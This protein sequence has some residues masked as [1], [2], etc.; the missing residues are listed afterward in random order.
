[1]KHEDVLSLKMESYALPLDKGGYAA[2]TAIPIKLQQP[3]GPVTPVHTP[4]NSHSSTPFRSPFQ[5]L[6]L[7]EYRKQQKS[8]SSP[9]S[10]VS[11]GRRIKRKAAASRLNEL[12][13]VPSS[14]LAQGLSFSSLTAPDNQQHDARPSLSFA[15]DLSS[16]FDGYTVATRSSISLASD[17]PPYSVSS[18]L[19]SSP[20]STSQKSINSNYRQVSGRDPS[21][22]FYDDIDSVYRVYDT[23]RK[24]SAAFKPIK[25]LPKPVGVRTVSSSISST[26]SEHPPTRQSSAHHLARKKSSVSDVSISRFPHPLQQNFP[27]LPLSDDQDQIQAKQTSYVT[28]TITPPATPTTIHYRG[29]SFDLLNPHKSLELHNI[30]SP[31]RE[32]E[33][34]DYFAMAPIVPAFNYDTETG[35]HKPSRS[36]YQDFG[37]AYA[38]ITKNSPAASSSHTSVNADRNDRLISGPT[39]KFNE[40]STEAS[41]YGNTYELLASPPTNGSLSRMAIQPGMQREEDLE[42]PRADRL[43]TSL[44]SN[45]EDV[46]TSNEDNAV[47]FQSTA[48]QTTPLK[49]NYIPSHGTIDTAHDSTSRLLLSQH[50]S[51]DSIANVSDEPEHGR[52][53]NDNHIYNTYEAT[54][55]LGRLRDMVPSRDTPNFVDFASFDNQYHPQPSSRRFPLGAGS[56]VPAGSQYPTRNNFEIH[57]MDG[58]NSDGIGTYH[59]DDYIGPDRPAIERRSQVSDSPKTS[60]PHFDATGQNQFSHYELKNMS[61]TELHVGNSNPS[62]PRFSIER[63]GSPGPSVAESTD[64]HLASLHH[65]S[66][67]YDKA[68]QDHSIQQGY[69]SIVA[70]SKKNKYEQVA[71]IIAP[72]PAHLRTSLVDYRRLDA[73]SLDLADKSLIQAP[74]LHSKSH[75]KQ[76]AKTLKKHEE[77]EFFG[78]NYCEYSPLHPSSTSAHSSNLYSRPQFLPTFSFESLQTESHQSRPLLRTYLPR[79]TQRLTQEVAY[80][81]EIARWRRSDLDEADVT[82]VKRMAVIFCALTFL[83]PLFWLFFF[84]GSFTGFVTWMSN[85]ECSR[86]PKAVNRW[87][88]WYA[89]F[90]S[91]FWGLAVAAVVVTLVL[92]GMGRL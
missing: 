40:S 30:D 53:S 12:E 2:I 13:C 84:T 74:R 44:S 79:Q 41:S 76:I 11:S 67:L 88:R 83:P 70:G 89:F 91:A 86:V 87:L 77:S 57:N 28:T 17:I 32:P 23:P 42:A 31:D 33:H 5:T 37:G 20:G 16:I 25:R 58:R 73:S 3:S 8:I 18:L 68:F 64:S 50:E 59:A 6:T 51:T 9:S 66:S 60:H 82:N 78:P 27:P 36:L 1:V 43:R 15:R 34:L 35:S 10:T 26:K 72:A 65:R 80:R 55:A 22:P 92:K 81:A 21:T 19:A 54:G 85:G 7:H 71:D 14:S 75:R 29:A 48:P 61:P 52:Y 46:D 4:Q 49:H 45:W 69:S 39:G 62:D 47:W 24:R 56:S 63:F 90:Y 38:A